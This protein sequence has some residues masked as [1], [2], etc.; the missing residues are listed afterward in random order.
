MFGKTTPSKPKAPFRYYAVYRYEY[1]R[2]GNV[3]VL[4]APDDEAALTAAKALV[5]TGYGHSRLVGVLREDGLSVKDYSDSERRT[6][7]LEREL[8]YR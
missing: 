6:A 1:T 3:E 5:G 8:G 2:E 4:K 7:D